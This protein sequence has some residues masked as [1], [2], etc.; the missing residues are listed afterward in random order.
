VETSFIAYCE[1]HI[2]GNVIIIKNIYLF[3]YLNVGQNLAS[4]HQLSFD[5]SEC[6]LSVHCQVKLPL[7]I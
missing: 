5:K 4:I 7:F 1:V 2:N 6:E 3:I